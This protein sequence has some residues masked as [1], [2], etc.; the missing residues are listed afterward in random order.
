M[1]GPSIL[2]PSRDPGTDLLSKITFA[3]KVN[4]TL[5]NDLPKYFQK[6]ISDLATNNRDLDTNFLKSQV[7]M[8][9]ASLMIVEKN[10]TLEQVIHFGK[11]TPQQQLAEI[12]ELTANNTGGIGQLA[13]SHALLHAIGYVCYKAFKE[14]K[15]DTLAPPKSLVA[16]DVLLPAFFSAKYSNAADKAKALKKFQDSTWIAEKCHF[17]LIRVIEFAHHSL[18]SQQR[19]I[20]ALSETMF[21][22]DI[23]SEV[24]R[25]AIEYACYVSDSPATRTHRL[26]TKGSRLDV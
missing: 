12:P 8:F 23:E 7:E 10:G 11:K 5:A 21:P 20:P 6:K 24:I 16:E 2:I 13:N 14:R 3:D 15:S 26:F 4:R 19:Q 25:D 1:A 18:E 17:S 22:K 9:R